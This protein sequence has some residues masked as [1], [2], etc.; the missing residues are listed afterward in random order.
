M[1]E[2]HI[3][4]V[5]DSKDVT[6]FLESYLTQQGY[7]VQ[8]AYNG[9]T[10]VKLFNANP[11]DLVLTDMQMPRL[12]GLGVLHRVKERSPDAQVIIMTA[13]GSLETA[14]DAMRH[15]AFDYL[16]KPIEPV[17]TLDLAIERA[18]E[19]QRLIVENRRLLK[20]LQATNTQLE[21]KVT[22]QTQ[23]L[24]DAYEQLQSLD[25][26][27]SEFVSIVSHELRTP[28]SVMLLSSQILNSELDALSDERRQEHLANLLIYGRRLKRLVENLLDFSLLGQGELELERTQFSIMTVIQEIA[29]SF[30]PHAEEKGVRLKV[31]LPKANLKID[32]DSAR[33]ANA[34]SQ[35]V[36]NAIKFTASGGKVVIGAHGPVRAPDGNKKPHVVIA[37]VDTGVGIAVEQQRLLFKAFTQVDMSDRRK[38]EGIGLGLALANRIATA[39]GGQITLK[40]EPQKGSTFAIWLPLE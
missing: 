37:V 38:Y 22:D 29:D 26:M 6:A 19:H 4:V 33:V 36:D 23:E 3:L 32:A 15:G 35:L 25:K 20:E 9:A 17:E 7:T 24:Q 28:L 11:S 39:H 8:V 34:L 40:S 18:L 16:L 14:L 10:A 5:D 27:K 21:D 30:K 13:H 12:N 1:A 31:T 2:G